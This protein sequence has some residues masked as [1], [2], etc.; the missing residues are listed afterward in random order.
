M[1]KKGFMFVLAV[2]LALTAFGAAAQEEK[3]LRIGIN[4]EVLSL[5]PHH[6]PGAIIGNRIY[7]LIFDQLT[8]T[9]TDGTVQPMLATAWEAV[10]DTTWVFTL[11]PDV[12]FQDGTTMTAED[13][14]YSLN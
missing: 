6:V 8:R 1:F 4:A 7:H 12:K 11:R 2:L 5:D 14:A 13:V 10:D 3:V 9:D